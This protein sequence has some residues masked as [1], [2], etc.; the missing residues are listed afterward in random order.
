MYITK[1]HIQTWRR[2]GLLVRGEVSQKVLEGLAW[3]VDIDGLLRVNP[4]D[5]C[6]FSVMS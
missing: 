3:N 2:P 6:D 4:N 5:H 1:T